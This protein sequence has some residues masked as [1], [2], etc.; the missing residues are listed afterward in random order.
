MRCAALVLLFLIAA[1]PVKAQKSGVGYYGKAVAEPVRPLDTSAIKIE[2]RLGEQVPLDLP[3]RDE[4]GEEITLGSCVAGKP[5]VLVLAYYHC[6]QMCTAVIGD[7]LEAIKEIKK[8]NV[9]EDF[10]VVVVSFDPKDMAATA[11][12]NKLKF[13]KEYGRAGAD[14]G[15]HFLCGEQRYIDEICD[16]VGFRYEYDK[17]RKQYNHASGIMVITPHG[18]ISKYVFGLKYEPSEV[19]AAL[20]EAGAGKIG[21]EIPGIIRFLLCGERDEATGQYTLSVMKGLRIIFGT[22]VLGLGIWL[23]RVW[24]RPVKTVSLTTNEAPGS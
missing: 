5:T 13:V 22:M 11:Y 2:Q 17:V 9:G 1:A 14:G 16:A 23:V 7:M 4:H 3:F 19:Q 12:E 6:P 24:R 18:K 10:N 8:L 15:V 21:Q 20:K